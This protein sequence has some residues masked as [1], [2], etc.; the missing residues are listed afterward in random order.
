MAD[1]KTVKIM[2][3]ED[4]EA[5]ATMYKNIL[6]QKGFQVDLAVDGQQALDLLQKGGYTLALLDVR[7]PQMDG[8]EV[9]RNL[10]ANPPEVKNGP[11]VMLTNLSDE[12]LVKEATSLGALSYMDKSNLEPSQLV[13]KVAGVLGVPFPEETKV[14]ESPLTV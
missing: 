3:A 5:T 8:L 9:L 6:E 2:L 10:K 13:Q 11:I 7:M 4:H 1:T 14:D 12:L